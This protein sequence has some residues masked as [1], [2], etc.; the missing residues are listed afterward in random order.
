M[1]NIVTPAPT[2]IVPQINWDKFDLYDTVIQEC[3]DDFFFFINWILKPVGEFSLSDARHFKQMYNLIKG[4]FK[5]F[6]LGRFGYYRLATENDRHNKKLGILPRIHG[7]TKVGTTAFSMWQLYKNPNLRI[8]IMSQTWQN[9][10]DMLDEI[11]KLYET[12]VATKNFNNSLPYW[13][14]GGDWRGDPWN[15]D[16]MTVK[17]RTKIDK[18]PSICTAGIE[19]EVTSTH[20]D[21]VIGDDL[22]GEQNVTTLEQ[23]EKTKRHISALSEIGDYHRDR[24]TLFLFWGTPWHFSDWYSDAINMRKLAPIFDILHLRC[25]DI[26]THE[27][28]FPEKYTKERL[29]AIKKEKFLQDPAE[30][31][32]QWLCRPIAEESAVFNIKNIQW[33]D[34]VPK[35]LTVVMPIDVALSKQKWSDYTAIAPIGLDDHGRIYVL[36]Y[37]QFKESDTAKVADRIIRHAKIYKNDPDKDLMM[38][39]IEKGTLYNALYPILMKFASWLPLVPLDIDNK[40]KMFLIAQALQPF[41]ATKRLYLMRNMVELIEQLM[42]FPLITDNDLINAVALHTLMIPVHESYS[43]QERITPLTTQE[44]FWNQV[45]QKPQDESRRY[46]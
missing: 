20:Y 6:D 7:K 5:H 31:D 25:W 1:T 12:I 16:R 35:K 44:N 43:I 18:T 40:N 42:K 10:R 39:G 30:W 3:K 14:M 33:Y 15:Q 19:T 29:E 32:R 9:A 34:A 26:D 46:L 27:P 13:I 37:E 24:E 4:E 38:I 28:L 36:P 21:I 11:E 8:M 22:I 2:I 45:L 41:V 23:V 17:M